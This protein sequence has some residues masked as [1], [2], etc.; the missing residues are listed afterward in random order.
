MDLVDADRANAAQIHVI[1]PPGHGHRD[2]P[3]DLVPAGAKVAR[4][5]LPTQALG[6]RREKPHV[7]RRELVLPIGPRHVLDAHTTPR[8]IDAAHRVEKEHPQA[9]EWDELETA[10]RQPVVD[11]TRLAAPRAPRSVAAM[12]REVHRLRQ[13]DR[14]NDLRGTQR[15][16]KMAVVGF[17]D[18][19]FQPLTHPSARP[20]YSDIS[21]SLRQLRCFPGLR[22]RPA[23]STNRIL[24]LC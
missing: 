15:K 9:P 20:F 10:R 2:R 19:P 11:A 23:P 8:A 6:P 17:Q 21:E 1:P 3:K 7:N 22:C 14:F 5:L 18:H 13:T 24:C 12:R 4:H 16:R